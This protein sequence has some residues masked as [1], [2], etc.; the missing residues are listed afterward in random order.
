[1]IRAHTES[2][3]AATSDHTARA[4]GQPI[5]AARGADASVVSSPV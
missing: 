5:D 1:M 4:T 2:P 3:T